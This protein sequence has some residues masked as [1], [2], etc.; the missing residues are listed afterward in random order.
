[1]KRSQQISETLRPYS[2]DLGG[3]KLPLD[4]LCGGVLVTGAT[5]SG[6]T[7]SIVNNLANQFA[8]LCANDAEHKAALFYFVVKGRPHLDFLKSLPRARRKD[9]VHLSI[10]K[11]DYVVRLF[12]EDCWASEDSLL[13]AAPAFLEEFGAHLD[14]TLGAIRH[15]PFWDRQRQRILNQLA[16]LRVAG[17]FSLLGAPDEIKALHHPDA[18]VRLI[19]RLDAFVEHTTANRQQEVLRPQRNID[20]VASFGEYGFDTSVKFHAAKLI[21]DGYITGKF[22]RRNA[23]EVASITQLLRLTRSL[24]DQAQQALENGKPATLLERLNSTL[25]TESSNQLVHLLNEWYAIAE[26][27]RGCIAADL[28]GMTESFRAGPM[29]HIFQSEAAPITLE[30]IID[31]GKILIIDLPLADTGDATLAPMLALKL[32]LFARLLGRASATHN[33]RPLSRRPVAVIIDEFHSLLSRGRTGGEDQFLSRCREFGVTVV[34]A[35]QSLS[36]VAGTLRDSQKVHALAANCRTKVFGH[37]SDDYTNSLASF[38]CGMSTG[39]KIQRSPVWHG[40]ELFRRAITDTNYGTQALVL[41]FRFLDL[42]T[43]QFYLTTAD[44]SVH[45][46]DLDFSLKRPIV[47]TLRRPDSRGHDQR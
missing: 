18:L 44:H 26:Q 42:I 1:M 29:M 41:P 35:S 5:G 19:N 38:C 33:G 21:L 12:S 10:D 25:S 30:K 8:H 22:P 36:L 32:A 34:L 9:V 20:L 11:N 7:V 28:R 37:N 6:K 13:A 3:V 15:D 27:T 14:D 17:T 23:G 43:G 45:W 31:E 47:K 40:S 46:L 4:T 16:T 39:A 24:A 2:L